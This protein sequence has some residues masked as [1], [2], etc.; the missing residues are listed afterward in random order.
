MDARRIKKTQHTIECLVMEGAQI[1]A[2][3]A[4]RA[5]VPNMT[6]PLM[7]SEELLQ[8]NISN[9]CTE[10]VRGSAHCPRTAFRCDLR[11]IL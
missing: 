6:R 9:K 11:S 3:T 5:Y 1:L 8:T 4:E 7:T 2:M 10:L